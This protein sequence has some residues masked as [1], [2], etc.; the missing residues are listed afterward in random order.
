MITLTVTYD[1]HAI[2]TVCTSDGNHGQDEPNLDDVARMLAGSIRTFAE[3]LICEP[4]DEPLKLMAE[5]IGHYMGSN[6]ME[7]ATVLPDGQVVPIR[8]MN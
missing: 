8:G 1:G 3:L 5:A 4:G 2:K 6:T 7:R